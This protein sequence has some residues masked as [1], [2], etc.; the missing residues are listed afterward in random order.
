M[1]KFTKLIKHS[2]VLWKTSFTALGRRRCVFFLARRCGAPLQP[3]EAYGGLSLEEPRWAH[4][5]A[6]RVRCKCRQTKQSS[7]Q[8]ALCMDEVAVD[9]VAAGQVRAVLN[10]PGCLSDKA[11]R[12]RLQNK[13]WIVFV[14]GDVVGLNEEHRGAT[15]KT[16]EVSSEIA[17]IKTALQKL[18]PECQRPDFDAMFQVASRRAR[19]SPRRLVAWPGAVVASLNSGSHALPMP[20][21]PMRVCLWIRAKACN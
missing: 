19:T 16:N 6:V 13:C 14:A 15:R 8:I 21:P 11:R 2:F 20:W 4:C 5:F 10:W 3:S 18:R 12:R 1:L 9:R 17:K 7:C